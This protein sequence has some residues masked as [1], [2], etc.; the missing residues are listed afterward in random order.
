MGFGCTWCAVAAP[1]GTRPRQRTLMRPATKIRVEVRI[2]APCNASPYKPVNR[3]V[4]TVRSCKE[5]LQGKR[6]PDV[7]DLCGL[8]VGRSRARVAARRDSVVVRGK[9]PG[10]RVDAHPN[11]AG[12]RRGGM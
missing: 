8:L 6:L 3:S 4:R 2:A 11:G 5:C 10:Q 1:T 9:W 12:L 7:L